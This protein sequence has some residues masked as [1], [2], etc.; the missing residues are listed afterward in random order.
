MG[1]TL[2][3]DVVVFWTLLAWK[4]SKIQHSLGSMCTVRFPQV[5]ATRGLVMMGT[6]IRICVR[7]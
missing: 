7:Q 2:I 1:V 6:W 3:L 4:L 5:N